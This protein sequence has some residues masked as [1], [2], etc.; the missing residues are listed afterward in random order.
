[1]HIHSW[2]GSGY[3]GAVDPANVS[4]R[5]TKFSSTASPHSRAP[6][7]YKRK[8]VFARDPPGPSNEPGEIRNPSLSGSVGVISYV[9]IVLFL[10]VVMLSNIYTHLPFGVHKTSV[11]SPTPPRIS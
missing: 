5:R 10:Y 7:P 9:D 1:M 2:P 3:S 4:A 6:R 11:R 8:V